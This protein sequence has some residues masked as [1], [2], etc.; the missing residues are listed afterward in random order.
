MSL[1]NDA[2]L[3]MIP[4]AVKDGKLYS[5][6]PKEILGNELVVN[7]GFNTDSDWIKGIGIT[8]ADGVARFTD[9]V[10]YNALAQYGLL[11]VGKTYKITFN[12]RDFSGGNFIVQETP[13]VNPPIYTAVGIGD[14]DHNI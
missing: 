6:K 2:S 10:P 9:C 14:G 7:G 8:I 1:Y 5:L 11:E 4:S 13:N 3:V 12:I